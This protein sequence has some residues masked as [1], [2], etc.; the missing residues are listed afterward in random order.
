[1]DMQFM[2]SMSIYNEIEL[3]NLNHKLYTA[4]VF[5]FLWKIRYKIYSGEYELGG[6]TIQKPISSFASLFQP[7]KARSYATWLLCLSIQKPYYRLSSSK[8]S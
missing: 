6:S 8:S 4:K 2:K 3:L 5:F 7:E 1:M